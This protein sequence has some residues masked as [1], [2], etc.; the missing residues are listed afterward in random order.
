MCESSQKMAM[1]SGYCLALGAGGPDRPPLGAERGSFLPAGA[2]VVA[3]GVS[4]KPLS[5]RRAACTS[6]H[7]NLSHRFDT[8]SLGAHSEMTCI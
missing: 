1:V 2:P 6:V 4:P 3:A 8:A 7:L 5:P